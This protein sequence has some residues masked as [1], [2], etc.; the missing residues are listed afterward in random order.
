M[1]SIF[2]LVSTIA[3]DPHN[4]NLSWNSAANHGHPSPFIL[5]PYHFD[6]L[7]SAAALHGW[8]DAISWASFQATCQHAIQQYDGPG[9]G[10][11]FKLRLVLHR[12]GNIATTVTPISPRTADPMLAAHISP[13]MDRLPQALGDPIT[14][15]LDS[16][17]TPSSLFTTT[18]TT[19]RS[20]YAAAR[21][22]FGLPDVGGSA[23]VLLWNTKGILTET[24]V[25]NVA[26]FRRC[27]WVT[28]HD[29]AGCLPGVTRRWLLE[30][31]LVVADDQGLLTT[32]Q[33]QE[34]EL[35]LVFNAVEGCRIAVTRLRKV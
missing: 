27:R 29:S 8:Q 10:G 33:V 35:A 3:C 9:K 21:A 12:A 14:L 24:S 7:R 34:G 22:R 11:P 25:R 28:P 6:R 26:F 13:A 5:L 23:D 31:G 30:Q 16:V 15:F 20:H 19:N 32:D 4:L 17:P 18:K 2:Q 1:S